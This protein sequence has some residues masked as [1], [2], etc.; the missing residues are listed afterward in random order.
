VTKKIQKIYDEAQSLK[1]KETESD[2]ELFGGFG[3]KDIKIITPEPEKN[4]TEMKKPEIPIKKEGK[5]Q[6]SLF[7]F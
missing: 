1:D 6:S 5:S 7:D 4:K 2:V 3:S